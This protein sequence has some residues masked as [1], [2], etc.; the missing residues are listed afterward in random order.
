MPKLISLLPI[1]AIAIFFGTAHPARSDIQCT[2]LDEHGFELCHSFDGKDGEYP[3]AGLAPDSKGN[4]YSST[5]GALGGD[6]PGKRCTKSC[7]D[8][9]AL[10]Q[11]SGNLRIL[12]N[13]A[14]GQA[15][16]AFPVGE[17]VVQGRGPS[18]A[19]F[20]TTEY[21]PGVACEGL[22][23]G[24]VFGLTKCVTGCDQKYTET[25]LKLC[26]QL[27][28]ESGAYP[29]GGLIAD[30]QGT[31][32][33]T[34]IV[35]GEGNGYLCGSHVGGCG[36]I[37][38]VVS[39]GQ[40]GATL[41]AI[42]HFCT[43]VIH[44]LCVDGANPIGRLLL[45]KGKLYGTTQFGGKYG[46]GVVFELIPPQVGVLW[47]ET[48]LYSFC[49]QQNCKDG[50]VPEAGISSDGTN[51]YGTTAEGGMCNDFSLGCGVV[52][53]LSP[54]AHGGWS[55]SVI[56]TFA[57]VFGTNSLADGA[58]PQNQLILDSG[59]ILYGT[60]LQG[61]YVAGGRSCGVPLFTGCGTVFSL[62]TAGTDYRILHV[63]GITKSGPDGLRPEGAL[64][65]RDQYLYGAARNGGN[66][67]ACPNGCGTL[68]RIDLTQSRLHSRAKQRRI[69]G[70]EHH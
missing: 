53:K 6:F 56:H 10:L 43:K 35:G 46:R 16:G 31:L 37:Y 9:N 65:L 4:L 3:E 20:G 42:Y 62:T 34:T 54:Q 61:G 69:F 19:I 15:D 36:V 29:R 30:A 49:A 1:L 70:A 68:Y 66:H 47:G 22:G 26:Q 48:I 14:A 55:E 58:L 64:L 51:I 63:F 2:A 40:E 21:G 24:T 60:T 5:F 8:A 50:A 45:R 59:G 11:D 12:H 44:N 38:K 52:F 28:C 33:G 39:A 23:C 41:S 32:Y 7:G 67:D 13:F 27:P 25:I 57:G 17:L 18:L